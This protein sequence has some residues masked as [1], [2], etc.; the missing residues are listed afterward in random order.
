MHDIIKPLPL[1]AS[2]LLR[3]NFPN[4]NLKNLKNKFFDFINIVVINLNIININKNFL[5]LKINRYLL[6]NNICLNNYDTIHLVNSKN[7]FKFKNF[8]KVFTYFVIKIK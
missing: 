6:A 5:T 2:R 1:A 3:Y 4:T 7:L 8:V